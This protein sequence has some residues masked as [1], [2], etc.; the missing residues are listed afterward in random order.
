MNPAGSALVFRN[1]ETVFQTCSVNCSAGQCGFFAASTERVYEIPAPLHF[2][3]SSFPPAGTLR[4]RNMPKVRGV[5][6]LQTLGLP[7]V[8]NITLRRFQ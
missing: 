5:S 3:M 7:L 4:T 2:A 1:R 6:G 8:L